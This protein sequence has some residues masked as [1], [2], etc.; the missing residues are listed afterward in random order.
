MRLIGGYDQPSA[1]PEKNELP[2][3]SGNSQGAFNRRYEI[4]LAKPRV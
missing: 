1:L 4:G 3:G 2:T